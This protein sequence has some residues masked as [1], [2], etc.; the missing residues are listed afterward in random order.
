MIERIIILSLTSIGICCTFWDG[1]I[2]EKVG[3]LIR[4]KLGKILKPHATKERQY[5][6]GEIAAKPLFGCYV[7]ATFWHSLVICL[8]VGWPFWLAV[9]AMG[10]SAVISMLQHD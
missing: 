6:V 10:L 2:F 3:D 7:C 8:V 1:M 9:P 4:I 5:S